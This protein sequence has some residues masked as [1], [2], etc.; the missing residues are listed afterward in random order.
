LNKQPHKS[1][2]KNKVIKNKRD[3]MGKAKDMGVIN[4]GKEN[5]QRT[6]Q[7]SAKMN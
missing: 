4:Q 6:M 5:P 1:Q 7:G 3:N 2:L